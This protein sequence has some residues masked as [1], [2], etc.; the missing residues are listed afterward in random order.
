[1]WSQYYSGALKLGYINAIDEG[2]VLVEL[3]YLVTGIAGQR[4]WVDT[5]IGGLTLGEFFFIITLA[6]SIFQSLVF[7]IDVRKSEA[8]ANLSW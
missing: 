7:V 8:G 6:T 5:H 3:T 4:I 2:L 1:M